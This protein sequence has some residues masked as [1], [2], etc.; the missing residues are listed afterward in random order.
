MCSGL[1]FASS[2]T[3][4]NSDGGPT[5]EWFMS[6]GNR[7]FSLGAVSGSDKLS[8][9]S[10]SVINVGVTSITGSIDLTLSS[11]VIVA[12]ANADISLNTF[13]ALTAN[14]GLTVSGSGMITCGSITLSAPSVLTSSGGTI[15]TGAVSG[16]ATLRIVAAGVSG[17]QSVV[18]S[19]TLPDTL[20]FSVIS[21]GATIL[22]QP[23]G[24]VTA[25]KL[26][27]DGQ[28]SLTLP[29]AAGTVI[30]NSLDIND[31]TIRGSSIDLFVAGRCTI[32]ASIR[33]VM[34]GS[35]TSG[36]VRC[37][38]TLLSGGGSVFNIS[39]ST[40]MEGGVVATGP[41]T[42]VSNSI[43]S[44]SSLRPA[45]LYTGP[46]PTTATIVLADTEVAWNISAAHTG[47]TQ[48]RGGV[49]LTVFGTG[50]LNG[51]VAVSDWSSG[52]GNRPQQLT[53]NSAVSAAGITIALLAGAPGSAFVLGGN[54][55]FT[56]DSTVSVRGEH[57]L[58]LLT[59]NAFSLLFTGHCLLS[60][61]GPG[62]YSGG[63]PLVSVDTECEVSPG[64]Y[65]CEYSTFYTHVTT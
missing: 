4:V 6:S 50:S 56:A 47:L 60:L 30:L 64:S 33:L 40:S 55:H 45:V 46:T 20:R 16:P 29:I 59:A 49:N 61:V 62:V 65:H 9:S 17:V 43:L 35:A 38:S 7:P 18:T 23:A 12:T 14:S 19:T 21:S 2:V 41:L 31:G 53:V 51:A 3:E 58:T 34:I 26:V 48:L 36:N 39:L 63:A 11:T 44:F 54:T 27:K 1:D 57:Q 22:W 13:I 52:L 10:G 32:A 42:A 15:T 28:G 24:G 37:G 8:I 5:Q 25:T